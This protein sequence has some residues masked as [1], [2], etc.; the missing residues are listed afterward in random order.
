EAYTRQ[1]RYIPKLPLLPKP[2]LTAVHNASPVEARFVAQDSKIDRLDVLLNF[3]PMAQGPLNWR[4]RQQDA[5]EDLLEAVLR[6]PLTGP[7]SYSLNVSLYTFTAGQTYIL[8]LEA[9]AVTA[10]RP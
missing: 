4:L 1:H 2:A 10:Q 5:S 7:A 9:P 8:T 6:Q 3:P